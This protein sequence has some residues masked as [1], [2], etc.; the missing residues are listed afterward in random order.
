MFNKTN[1]KPFKILALTLVM[2]FILPMTIA[3]AHSNISV[4]KY[5]ALG[6]SISN[7]YIALQG[8]TGDGRGYVDLFQGNVKAATFVNLS[9]NGLTTSQLSSKISNNSSTIR[10]S[11]LITISIGSNN[12]LVP[13]VVTLGTA[14]GASNP[15]D[16]LSILNRI[17]QYP[18]ASKAILS[19]YSNPNSSYSKTLNATLSAGLVSL[20]IDLPIIITKIKLL[21][22]KAEIYINNLYNPIT[23]TND[24]FYGLFEKYICE[25]N[26]VINGYNGKYNIKVVDVYTTFKNSNYVNFSISTALANINSENAN[27]LQYLDPHPTT[28]G[29]VKIYEQLL[30][31]YNTY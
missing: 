29:H 25:A 20:K 21:A 27:L 7:G 13:A 2:F 6:D 28:D 12:L 8:A 15:A 17:T 31:K 1:K 16:P 30:L 5:V 24:P 11:N 9:E 3:F 14:L 19:Q 26:N 23:N 4:G 10:N 22:P 18:E